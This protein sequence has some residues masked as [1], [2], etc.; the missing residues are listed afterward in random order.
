[1]LFDADPVQVAESG[2]R[3]FAE[4]EFGGAV[5]KAIQL[6][7]RRR[8]ESRNET[9]NAK[10]TNMPYTIERT[11][12]NNM[13]A[14]N[15]H[16]QAIRAFSTAARPRFESSTKPHPHGPIRTFSTTSHRLSYANTIPNLAINASTRV[17]YQGFTGRAATANAL[18]TLAYGTNIVGGVSP[19]AKTARHLDLPLYA[20]ALAAKTALNPDATAVFVP[21]P[22]AAAAM[23][24]AVAAEIPLIV[25]VAEHIPLHDMLRVHEALLTQSKSRLVGPNCPG[26]I[27]P[28]ARCRI[29][30]MPYLQYLPGCIGIASKSGTLSY[31][32]VGATTRAG[33]GQSLCVGVGGDMLPGTSLVDALR[34]LTADASTRGIVV[35]G[36]IGGEAE[37]EAAAFLK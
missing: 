8:S 14:P 28:P 16:Q 36:E 21:A 20:S 5:Q 26:I 37:L 19:I 4:D 18:A 2:L 10:P 25:S 27:A 3:L 12:V 32:A 34:V 6:S 15:S 23:L 35:L 7:E 31:E 1:M 11:S 13:P 29:G 24:E 33:L 17:I 9:T 30:I 22:F